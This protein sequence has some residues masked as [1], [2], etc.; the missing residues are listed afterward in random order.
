ME[1]QIM[2]AASGVSAPSVS[3]AP[4]TASAAPEAIAL[5]RPGRRPRL[6]K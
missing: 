3:S 1:P 2:L 5:R 4:P 6:S